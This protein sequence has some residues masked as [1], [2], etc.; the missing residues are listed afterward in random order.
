MLAAAGIK[1]DAVL[2]GAGVRFNEAVPSPEAFNHLITHMTVGGKEVWLDTTAEI[3]PYRMLVPPIRDKQALV[4]SAAGAAFVART[5]ADP[6]FASFQTMDADGSIDKNGTSHS[7]L[8]LTVRGDTE[9]ALREAFRQTAPAQY[10][11]LVQQMV[12]GIGYA[13]TTSNAEAMPPEDMTG[14]FRV[15]FDY[16]R[17]KAGDWDNH[18]IVPQ[19]APVSLPRFADSDP[20]VRS[21]DLGWPRTETSHA[22]MK[23]PEGWTAVLPEAAHYKCA[24][25][26]YDRPTALRMGRCTPSGAWRC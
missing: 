20:L 3:A 16:E 2:I 23:I 17:E 11:E 8:T 9:L 5:P 14:P 25:A 24:Y 18:K 21:L 12:H 6:P 13:G 7:R 10:E 19:V 22:A 1:A 15:S 26:A 4:V